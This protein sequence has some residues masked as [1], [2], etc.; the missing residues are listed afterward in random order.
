MFNERNTIENVVIKQ[1]SGIDLSKNIEGL[2]AEPAVPYI[3]KKSE[4]Y[5]YSFRLHKFC[6]TYYKF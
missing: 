1:L 5:A 6:F 3:S 2:V 4:N